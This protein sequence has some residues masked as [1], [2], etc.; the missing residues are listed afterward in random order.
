MNKRWEGKAMPRRR[1]PRRLVSR[2]VFLAGAAGTLVVP[3]AFAQV[4][5]VPAIVTSDRARPL[6]PC[7]VMSSD[8]T[9]SRALLWSKTDRPARL[10][11]EVAGNEAF[12]NA[13]RLV[14]PAALEGSDFTARLDLAGL[15]P[16]RRCSIARPCWISAS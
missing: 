10:L 13:R 3:R 1:S 5:A 14:G 12:A 2:R 7:G 11:M 4:P 15:P 9:D 8:V 16:A 6:M